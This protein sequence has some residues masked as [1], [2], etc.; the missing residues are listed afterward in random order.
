MSTPREPNQ[1]GAAA[2]FGDP[3][4][5]HERRWWDGQRWTEKVAD[6]NLVGIDPPGIDT[7]PVQPG[8]QAP[9]DPILDAKL[10]ITPPTVAPQI[11]LVS[12]I[13]VLVAI[14]ALIVV[15]SITG[16]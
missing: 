3:F 15:F 10:P 12:G 2:W 8:E 14:I 13:I 4:G 1:P 16:I 9:A 6:E 5:R 7:A 11:A